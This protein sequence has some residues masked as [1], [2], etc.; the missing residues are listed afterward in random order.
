[1]TQSM[2]LLG[3][4]ALSFAVSG[5]GHHHHRHAA[6][7]PP[8]VVVVKPGPPPHA[9]AHGHRHRHHLHPDVELVFDTELGVYA[10]VGMHDHFFHRDHFYRVVDGVWYRSLRMGHGWVVI[11]ERSKLPPRLAKKRWRARKH[12][13]KHHRHPAKHGY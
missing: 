6:A 5:C 2:W 8:G 9:P 1:M 10:V 11:R 7:H 3:V 12:H 13:R 4:L